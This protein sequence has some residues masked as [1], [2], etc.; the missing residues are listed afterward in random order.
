VN[1]G[2]SAAILVRRWHVNLPIK[3]HRLT[4]LLL[5]TCAVFKAITASG[6][7]HILSALVK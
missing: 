5:P 2:E 6:Y 3:T 1:F 4:R 7:R